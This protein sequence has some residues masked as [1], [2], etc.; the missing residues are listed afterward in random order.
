MLSQIEM[1][2][3][4]LDLGEVQGVVARERSF[5]KA[6]QAYERVAT[7]LDGSTADPTPG[8]TQALNHLLT[9]LLGSPVL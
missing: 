8:L 3:L 4:L 2:N 1:A 5:A 9:R 6:K 7:L